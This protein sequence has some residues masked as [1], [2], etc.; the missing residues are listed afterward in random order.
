MILALKYIQSILFIEMSLVLK[1]AANSTSRLVTDVTSEMLRKVSV[2][3][4]IVTNMTLSLT[5]QIVIKNSYKPCFDQRLDVHQSSFS[6]N[7]VFTFKTFR[8]TTHGTSGD[9]ERIHAS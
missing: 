7:I 6:P 1:S 8:F 4:K 5:L 9:S 2:A 3:D